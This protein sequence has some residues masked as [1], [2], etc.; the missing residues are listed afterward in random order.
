MR[1]EVYAQFDYLSEVALWVDAIWEYM[2]DV[3]DK[4]EGESEDY[5]DL[6]AWR[7][8]LVAELSDVL[9]VE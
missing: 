9:E 2:G 3:W 7:D 4:H 8:D 1:H 5:D 6:K